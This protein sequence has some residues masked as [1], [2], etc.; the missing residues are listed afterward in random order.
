MLVGRGMQDLEWRLLGVG[1]MGVCSGCVVWGFAGGWCRCIK[2]SDVK[3]IF[4]LQI[5]NFVI[6]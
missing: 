5:T 3:N 1:F 2:E 6:I 4:N